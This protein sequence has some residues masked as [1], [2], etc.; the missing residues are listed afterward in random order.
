MAERVLD[1]VCRRQLTI[2]CSRNVRWL[3]TSLIKGAWNDWFGAVLVSERMRRGVFKTCYRVKVARSAGY[4]RLSSAA[5]RQRPV[6]FSSEAGWR[7]PAAR[8]P[9]LRIRCLTL[10]IRPARCAALH[11]R[12]GPAGR[13]AVMR[14]LACEGCRAT[15]HVGSSIVPPTGIDL[16]SAR[17]VCGALRSR[18]AS[19]STSYLSAVEQYRQGGRSL[20]GRPPV[21]EKVE[22]PEPA[23]SGVRACGR[24]RSM[25]LGRSLSKARC[26]PSNTLGRWL[27]RA[28]PHDL[29]PCNAATNKSYIGRDVTCVSGG[30]GAYLS[31]EVMVARRPDADPGVVRPSAT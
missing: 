9:T 14:A 2:D 15:T 31:T 26:A 10:K 23:G 19:T 27:T 17:P 7:S 21:R 4:D 1:C 24:Q 30:R 11:R 12:Q 29:L 16:R 3:G 25:N 28:A 20:L 18:S 13:A 5:D 22:R 6:R 8:L